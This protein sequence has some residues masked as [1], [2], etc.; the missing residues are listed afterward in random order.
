MTD[1]ER[2][3]GNKVKKKERNK[4]AREQRKSDLCIDKMTDHERE[5]E[6]ER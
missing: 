5:R 2:V 3:K 1:S 6:R 4:V